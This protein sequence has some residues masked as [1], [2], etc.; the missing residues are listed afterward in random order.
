MPSTYSLHPPM[1]ND[2]AF[3]ETQ[4][5]I[6]EWEPQL[7]VEVFNHSLLIVGLGGNGTHLAL[8]AVRMGFREVTGVDCDTIA[9]SNLN[10]QVLYTTADLGKEKA[11]QA[12]SALR[13]HNLHSSI[14]TIQ[15]DILT[16]RQ[17]FG[18]LVASCDLA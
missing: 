12:E 16:E 14:R 9:P 15:M 5:L 7:S 18:A 10:R 3:F 11:R 8:G 2:Q 17:Q 6:Q 13:L 4:N 1:S